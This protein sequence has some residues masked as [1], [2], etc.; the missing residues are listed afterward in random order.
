MSGTRFWCWDL[1]GLGVG[2]GLAPEDGL[3]DQPNYGPAASLAAG[4]VVRLSV[5]QF[6]HLVD[7]HPVAE[8][9][10]SLGLVSVSRPRVP[11]LSVSSRRQHLE[12]VSSRS[13]LGDK[14][15]SQSILG[16]VSKAK[17]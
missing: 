15:L 4:P 12:S 13:R 10:E 7:Q 16:L 9:D 2:R 17:Y 6:L 1:P 8:S 14:I 3:E 5:P 11:R